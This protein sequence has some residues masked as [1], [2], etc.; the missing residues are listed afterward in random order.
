MSDWR[1]LPE[2][3]HPHGY[4]Q[5]TSYDRGTEDF[6]YPLTNHGN[7]DFNNFVC[8]SANAQIAANQIAPFR[9]DM[10][11]CPE[12]YVRGVVLSRFEGS[13]HMARM[14]LGM[15]SLLLGPADDEVLRIYVDDDPRPR[16]DV[17][18]AE[19]FDGTAGEIF[20]PPF[21]AGSPSR[22]AWYYPVS[23]RQK[24]I[25]ALDRLGENDTYFYHCDVVPDESTN[26]P[27]PMERLPE[28]E[29]VQQQ[30]ARVF[31]P[32]GT[33][34]LLHEPID[35]ELSAGESQDVQLRGPATI[36]EFRVRLEE[37]DV[38]RLAQAQVRVHWDGAE[39]PAIDSSLADLL[40]GSIPPE[41]SSHA[42]TSVVDAADRVLSLKL[43]MPFKDEAVLSF[44]NTGLRTAAFQLRLIGEH[45]TP[46]HD[47]GHLYVQRTETRGPTNAASRIAVRAVGR[48]RL[49]GLCNEVQGHPDPA[50]GI[51]YDA[52]NLLEGDVRAVIDERLAL[53]GTGSEETADDVFYFLNAPYGNAF[54]QVWG[55][56]NDAQR[57]PGRAS[58]CSWHV[59]GRE[60]DFQESLE[61]TFELGGAANPSIVERH[62]SVA[63]LY[64]AAPDPAPP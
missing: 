7:R 51:Q 50:A 53:N 38:A 37:A 32:A 56:Q 52:L 11:Q 15:Q 29:D 25:V 23:F 22:L 60:L 33:H 34:G 49:V 21:G 61:L 41:R 43:P 10:P 26:D 16:I 1:R 4:V 55:V 62:K 46:K 31:H 40:G 12:D 48:G 42:L 47:W 19:A 13:G 18:L 39:G 24:L 6:T 45:T 64:R 8:A 28:R 59:L 17:P 2:L 36:H 27:L 35:I 30:L 57:P 14:W 9:Y 5:Q 58:F 54:A 63:Y 20:A 44:E 3:S